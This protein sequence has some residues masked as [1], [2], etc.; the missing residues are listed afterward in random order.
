MLVLVD[1]SNEL[2]ECNAP[3]PLLRAGHEMN[4]D[5]VD[6]V[7]KEVPEDLV[8]ELGLRVGDVEDVAEEEE[9][10]RDCLTLFRAQKVRLTTFQMKS[11]EKL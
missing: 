6:G 11:Y 9:S 4:Q 5:P 8:L 1:E 10:V 7:S 2:D 3:E